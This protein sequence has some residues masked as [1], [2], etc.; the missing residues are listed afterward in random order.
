MVELGCR[1]KIEV[2]ETVDLSLSNNGGMRKRW[3]LGVRM[4][5]EVQGSGGA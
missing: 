1:E 2:G 5:Q 3:N 4:T